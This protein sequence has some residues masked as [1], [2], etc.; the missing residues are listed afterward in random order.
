MGW[1]DPKVVSS[2]ALWVVFAALLNA[3]LRPAMRGRRVMVLTIVA[4]AFLVFTWAGVGVLLPTAHGLP[5]ARSGGL[6]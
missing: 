1:S 4:F 5:H 2:T 3:R 6:P